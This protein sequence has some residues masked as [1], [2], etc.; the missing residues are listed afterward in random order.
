MGSKKVAFWSLFAF[1]LVAAL[2]TFARPAEAGGLK[3]QVYLTQ[4]QI[5]RGLSEKALLGF[6]R[7]HNAK[8][9]Q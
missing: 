9:L 6:A 7:G 5:P 1:A 4:A 8:I 2:G 3:A